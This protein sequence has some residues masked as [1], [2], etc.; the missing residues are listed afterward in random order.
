MYHI[1]SLF[2]SEVSK[3]EV[4]QRANR[5]RADIVARYD[6]VSI[7]VCNTQPVEIA[8]TYDTVAEQTSM[9]RTTY[10]QKVEIV[11]ASLH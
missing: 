7:P 9:S 3:A 4:I 11:Y 2:V 5:E 1:L 8:Y 6:R 10:T